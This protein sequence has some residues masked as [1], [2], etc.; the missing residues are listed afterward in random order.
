[1]AIVLSRTTPPVAST[2]Q[3]D[4]E[5]DRCNGELESSPRC[6][7]P[8]RP[9]VLVRRADHSE[10]RARSETMRNWTAMRLTLA[11][12]RVRELGLVAPHVL[13]LGIKLGG[14]RVDDLGRASKCWASGGRADLIT[15]YPVNPTGSRAATRSAHG[16]R[17]SIVRTVLPASSSSAIDGSPWGE[18][19]S[20]RRGRPCGSFSASS[21]L[22]SRVPKKPR[23]WPK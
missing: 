1:M 8:W 15:G 19:L 22:P 7:A 6:R 4:S 17:R 12:M 18:T 20:T 9:R 2:P 23:G 3:P 11:V 21:A 14:V 13:N 5:S 16:V 10:P